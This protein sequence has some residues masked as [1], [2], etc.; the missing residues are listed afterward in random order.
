[1]I[2][3]SADEVKFH[4]QNNRSH[5]DSGHFLFPLH[6]HAPFA[7]ELEEQQHGENGGHRQHRRISRRIAEAVADDFRIDGDRQ[8]LGARPVQH[9]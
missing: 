5:E 6:A 1:M 3:T 4:I 7:G 9:D 8:G 2:S